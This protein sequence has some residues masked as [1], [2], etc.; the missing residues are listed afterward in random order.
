MNEQ[1]SEQPQAEPLPLSPEQEALTG[2]EVRVIEQALKGYGS[3]LSSLPSAKQQQVK[4][5]IQDLRRRLIRSALDAAA[6]RILS[7]S[8]TFDDL[9]LMADALQGFVRLTRRMVP[10]STERD[11]VLHG[12]RLLRE[13]LEKLIDEVNRQ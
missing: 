2:E 8:F 11:E 6:D 5:R 12:L 1:A 7:G 13:R 4:E 3:Y 9:E 10:R